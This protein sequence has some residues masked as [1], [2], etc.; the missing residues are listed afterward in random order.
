MEPPF[1]YTSHTIGDSYG[2]S[3]GMGVPSL[4]VQ[5][6]PILEDLDLPSGNLT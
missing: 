5:I 4:Q 1:S 3:M 6:P 2:S